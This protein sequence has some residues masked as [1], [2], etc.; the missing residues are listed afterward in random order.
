MGFAYKQKNV[1]IYLVLIERK[2]GRCGDGAISKHECWAI[3]WKEGQKD[4]MPQ[5]NNSPNHLEGCYRRSGDNIIGFNAGF[6]TM[7]CTAEKMCMCY[8]G[9]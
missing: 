3:R 2:S 5:H 6:S 8:M 1:Y 9:E 4:R 7:E